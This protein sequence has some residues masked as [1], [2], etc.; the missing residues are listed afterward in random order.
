MENQ[1]PSTNRGRSHI[2]RFSAHVY[3]GQTAGWIKM[4]LGMQV[5]LGPGH[6][7]LDG[8]QFPLRKK[9]AEP[10]IFGPFLLWPNGWMHQDPT[11]YGGS[12][13][14]RRLCVSWE[15]SSQ[16]SKRG[17]APNF[18]PTSIVAKQLHGSRCHLV[19][20]APPS[21]TP[22]EHPQFSANVRCGQTAG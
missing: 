4:A 13:Q 12:P 11:W 9:G 1:L 22:W 14:A 17:G 19:C 7:V 21:L 2:P 8:D 5:G 18:P 16:S 15:P 3:C 10:Q 6:I 20:P